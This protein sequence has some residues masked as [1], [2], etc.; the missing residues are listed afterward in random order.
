MAF[1]EKKKGPQRR[2]PAP[3]LQP[4]PGSVAAEALIVM[5]PE[6]TPEEMIEQHYSA[7][8]VL[9]ED[10]SYQIQYRGPRA[11]NLGYGKVGGPGATTYVEH[12]TERVMGTR[13]DA[14]AIAR[15]RMDLWIATDLKMLDADEGVRVWT[16][17]S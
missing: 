6:P 1:R 2:S 17:Y 5:P 4:P 12:L 8:I 3:V 13:E 15:R 7:K 10:G 9:R 14:E 11:L 16:P